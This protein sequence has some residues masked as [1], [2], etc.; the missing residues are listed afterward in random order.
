MVM[1]IKD[2]A[3]IESEGSRSPYQERRAELD[4]RVTEATRRRDREDRRLMRLTRL[5]RVSDARHRAACEDIAE[6]LSELR[7]MR[8]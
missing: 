2:H 1:T 7:G 6:A 3:E 8:T 5:Q 4:W